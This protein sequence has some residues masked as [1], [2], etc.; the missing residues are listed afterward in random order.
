MHSSKPNDQHPLHPGPDERKINQ[1]LVRRPFDAVRMLS[2]S[3]RHR[4]VDR[5]TPLGPSSGNLV[6]LGPADRGLAARRLGLA[7]SLNALL[8]EMTPAHDRGQ[9]TQFLEE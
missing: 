8:G 6:S 4:L 2:W 1:E 7:L 9:Q 5:S 3:S